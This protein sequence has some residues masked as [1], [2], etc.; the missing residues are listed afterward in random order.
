MNRPILY[1]DMD[2]VLVD[3][4]NHPEYSF[5]NNSNRDYINTSMRKASFWT[6]LPPIEYAIEAVE[7]L[8]DSERFDIYIASKPL[9][10]CSNSYSGKCEWIDKHLPDLAHKLI[11]TPNKAILRGDYL[12]DD[13]LIY[14]HGFKGKFIHF[15]TDKNSYCEWFDIKELLLQG[16][17]YA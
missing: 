15:K 4:Y 6:K 1:I 7:D 3:F 5:V 12:I 10:S 8:I 17:N 16:V 14:S 9:K 2:C 11:L 13:N